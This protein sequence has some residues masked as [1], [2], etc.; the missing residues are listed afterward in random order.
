MYAYSVAKKSAII[1][2]IPILSSE[3][4]VSPNP[5]TSIRVTSL[6][7]RVNPVGWTSAV[8][9]DLA[10][11]L[12]PLARSI[13]WRQ[14]GEFLVIITGPTLLTDVFPLPAAPMT[15]W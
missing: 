14:L 9:F 7:S 4:E 3:V 1:C 8:E 10:S 12:K 5:G 11:K 13:N 6:S 2:K 15:L